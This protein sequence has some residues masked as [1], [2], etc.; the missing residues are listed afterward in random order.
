MKKPNT[1]VACVVAY[2]LSKFDKEGYQ[3]LGFKNFNDAFRA[4]GEKLGLTPSAIKNRRDQYDPIHPNNRAGWYQRP[5]TKSRQVV[6]DQYADFTEEALREIVIGILNA[7]EAVEAPDAP[8]K[9]PT[10]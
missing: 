5:L 10:T 4:F 6:L 3:A 7:P 8:E 9:E 2:Y 1:E